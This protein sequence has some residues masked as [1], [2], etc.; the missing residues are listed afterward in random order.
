MPGKMCGEN[1]VRGD[2]VETGLTAM[3][4]L[5]TTLLCTCRN[6]WLIM[7]WW[8]TWTLNNTHIQHS[9]KFPFAWNSS[10]YRGGDFTTQK[11]SKTTAGHQM[12]PTMYSWAQC[13]QMIRGSTVKGTAW[14]K[15]YTI[16]SEKKRIAQK[17]SAYTS[18]YETVHNLW[19]RTSVRFKPTTRCAITFKIYV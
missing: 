19:N 1:N 7:M 8:R 16:I 12:H 9:V 11:D 14:N 15:H 17:S 4:V 2:T 18:Y 13:Y 3:T 5:L 6:F 10:C